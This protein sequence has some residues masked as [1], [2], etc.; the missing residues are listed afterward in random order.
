MSPSLL[1]YIFP[2]KCIFCANTL[3]AAVPICVCDICAA[4]LPYYKGEY[5]FESGGSGGDGERGDE[6]SGGG[7]GDERGGDERSG[8]GGIAR[9]YCDR[10]VCAL[11]YTGIVRKAVSGFKFQ[12]RREY[13]LTLAA[14]LCERLINVETFNKINE[15]FDI[16]TCVPL[17]RGRLRERG[18]NQAAVLANYTARCFNLFYASGLLARNEQTLRQSSLKRGE[19][20]ANVQSAFIVN[21]KKAHEAK[22]RLE[23]GNRRY[24]CVDPPAGDETNNPPLN[25]MR[26]LLIDD[27]ATSM[28]TINA[29]AASLKSEGAAQVVGAV[30]AAP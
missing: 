10:I 28:S 9:N 3:S 29:C 12:G 7:S 26:I 21:I 18:Y 1:S 16:V 4:K 19:R 5:L 22:T 14:L 24:E 6:S 23:A 25:G 15:S 11:K 20:R 27:I 8:G 2:K 13:G 17:S 30:L